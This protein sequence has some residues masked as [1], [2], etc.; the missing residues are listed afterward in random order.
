MEQ[1]GYLFP[2]ISPAISPENDWY[3][4]KEWLH[5]YPLRAKL[6]AQL[7]RDYTPQNPEQLTDE[8]IALELKKL[9]DLFADVSFQVDVQ[10]ELPS[11][12]LYAYLLEELEADF[13]VLVDGMWHLDGCDGYCPGCFQRPWCDCGSRSCWQEDEEAGK[14]VLI[15]LVQKYVS[16]TPASLQ[17]LQKYQAAEDQAFAEFK[18]NRN[19]GDHTLA[20]WSF[21]ADDDSVIPF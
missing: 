1:A 11:R 15:E 21:A 16:A 19:D 4:F 7:L 5:G 9:L 18:Q 20:P 12:L 10:S 14:M 13:D 8:E 6:K 2:P 17:L 3:R